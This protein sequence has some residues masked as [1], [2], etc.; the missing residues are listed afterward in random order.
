MFELGISKDIVFPL[1][2]TVKIIRTNM[3]RANIFEAL[4]LTALI[5]PVG[6]NLKWG[7]R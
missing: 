1:P 2:Y 3:K 6:P 7:R 5:V 4:F